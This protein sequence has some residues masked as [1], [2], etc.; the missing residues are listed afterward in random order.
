GGGEQAGAPI[1]GGIGER[2]AASDRS[3]IANRAVR[4]L[5]SNLLHQPTERLGK[6]AVFNRGMRRQGADANGARCR[7]NLLEL[8]QSPDIDQKVRQRHAQIEH[9]Q[10]RLAAGDCRRRTVC[11]QQGAGLGDGFRH[12]VVE[13]R[14]FHGWPS[15]ARRAASIASET[16]RGVSGVSLK[17]APISRNASAT[18]LAMAAG[19]A[20]APPSPSPFTPYSVVSAGVT[21]GTMRTEGISGADGTI[22]YA[23][24]VASGWPCSSYGISS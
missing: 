24:V 11:G 18:A 4:N 22:K 19:G 16:R 1:R 14:R 17:V 23:N 8:V 10:Q 5:G 20:I 2:D 6:L 12:G 9:R 15:F 21:R 3:V 13:S 7:R